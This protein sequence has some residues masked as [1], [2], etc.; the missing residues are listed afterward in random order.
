MQLGSHTFQLKLGPSGRVFCEPGWH[1]GPGWSRGLHDFDLWFVWRGRGT[2]LIDQR[3]EIALTPGVCL[4]MTPGRLYEAKQDP[5]DRLGVNFIHFDLLA[6]PGALPLSAFTPPFNWMRTGQIVFVDALM[7][8]VIDLKAEPEAGDVAP[9]LFTG[10]LLE[11]IR[12]H[13]ALG[14]SG[15]TGLDLHHRDK[16]LKSAALIRENPGHVPPVSELARAAGYS[17]DHFSRVFLKVTG[18]RPQDYVVTARI[19]RARQLLLESDLTVGMIAEALGFRDI[20][21]FSRQ[22]RQKTG[23]TPTAFRRSRR[24]A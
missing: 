18:S 1:L 22:F 13:A 19:E 2:M 14:K 21:F 20:F 9:A 3:E 15:A 4:W 6:T 11:L 5:E 24:R 17:V 16:V 10:L 12:E 23:Q 7:R 8:R